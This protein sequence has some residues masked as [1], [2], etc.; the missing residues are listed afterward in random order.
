ML[1]FNFLYSLLKNLYSFKSILKKSHPAFL[2]FS[3]TLKILVSKFFLAVNKTSSGT[4]IKGR[5]PSAVLLSVSSAILTNK[6][7]LT[8]KFGLLS[9]TLAFIE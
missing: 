6:L 3:I 8:F 4:I 5:W 2:H 1:P 9:I 7:H